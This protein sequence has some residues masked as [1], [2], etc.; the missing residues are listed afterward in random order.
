M[1]VYI[2]SLFYVVFLVFG[3]YFIF[4]SVSF[5]SMGAALLDTWY[6]R[7]TL[8]NVVEHEVQC[9]V[10]HGLANVRNSRARLRQADRH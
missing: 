8:I 6:Q 5:R 1:T 9:T 10:H 3:L 2:L 7:V 4:Y